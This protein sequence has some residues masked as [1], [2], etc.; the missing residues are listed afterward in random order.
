M[1]YDG[2]MYIKTQD[3]PQDNKILPFNIYHYIA[4]I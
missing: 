3:S 2:F 1:Y 4:P